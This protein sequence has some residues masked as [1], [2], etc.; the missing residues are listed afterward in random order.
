MQL[1]NWYQLVSVNQWSIDSHIKLSANYI[2]VHRLAILIGYWLLFQRKSIKS[3]RILSHRLLIDWYWFWSTDK[4]IDCLCTY[5]FVTSTCQM[6]NSRGRG[7]V[8]NAHGMPEGGMLMLQTDRCITPVP[9]LD[10]LIV[11]KSNR[12][13]IFIAPVPDVQKVITLV[14]PDF[15]LKHPLE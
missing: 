7:L 12:K 13:H 6:P 3:H 9:R 8:S 5:Q 15:A 14:S 1:V 11:Q 2:N 10:I 4:F